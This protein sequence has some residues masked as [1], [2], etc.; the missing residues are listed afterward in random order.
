MTPASRRALSA[1]NQQIRRRLP[2]HARLLRAASA[3]IAGQP[4]ADDVPP[5]LTEALSAP[6]LEAC[7]ADPLALG[8]IHQYWHAAARA[9]ADGRPRGG[10]TVSAAEV[11]RRTQLF[12]EPYLVDWILERTLGAAWAEVCAHN[13]WD[14]PSLTEPT[15][16]GLRSI[17]DLR[18]LDPAVGSGH[19][20]VS[21][22]PRLLA[23]HA[24]E[25]RLRG[26]RWS[27]E[28]SVRWILAHSL[29]GVDI[30]PEAV[31][32]ARAAL[33]LCARPFDAEPAGVI[34]SSD[35]S[36]SLGR[37]A[38]VPAAG[39]HHLV[40]GNPPYLSTAKLTDARYIR[41]AYPLGRA[42]LFAAFLLRGLE[43]TCPGG[44][45]A[46]LTPR[47][48]M[49]TRQY[50]PLRQ[51]LLRAHRLRGLC[52]VGTG[53]FADLSG[54][55][56]QVCVSVFCRDEPPAPPCRVLDL[57]GARGSGGRRVDFDPAALAVVPGQPLVY[58][59]SAA[60][61]ARFAAAP[62]L[63]ERYPVRQGLC[64][65]DNG[66]FL[67]RP[68]EVARQRVPLA[69][70]PADLDSATAWLPFIKGGEGARWFEPLRWVVNWRRGG[71][72]IRLGADAGTLAARPQNID[73]YLVK[74]TAV[75]TLGG[76]FAGRQ[77]RYPSV[78]GDMARSVFGDPDEVVTFLN[79]SRTAEEARAL[80][81][82][83]HVTVSDLKR[84]AYQ[85]DPAAG[86]I[87]AIL[88]AAFDQH[89]RH[90]EPSVT[91]VAPGPSPWAAAQS[92]AQAATDRPEGAPL[93]P[94][95]PAL[96]PASDADQL[97]HAFGLVLRALSG[98][99]LV[100]AAGGDDLSHPALAPLR[101]LLPEAALRRHLRRGFFV[102]HRAR[103]ADR[104]IYWPLCAPDR[105][106][107]VWV[108]AASPSPGLARLDRHPGGA[109]L[110]ER[111]RGCLD[112]G[113]TGTEQPA[114][115]EPSADDGFWVNSAPLHPVLSPLWATPAKAWAALSAGKADWSAMARRHWPSRVA[116]R[117]ATDPSV[118]VAHGRLWADHPA[119]AWRWS[120]RLPVPDDPARIGYIRQNPDEAVAAVA[121]EVR[122]RQGR[123]AA[124]GPLPT[125]SVPAG[126]WE[127]A[128][129]ACWALE[130]S[131]AAQQRAPFSLLAPDRAA[132]SVYLAQQPG[133]AASVLEAALLTE[134]RP[135]TPLHT[136]V[137]DAPALAGRLAAIA[138]AVARKQ[139]APISLRLPEA[140]ATRAGAGRDG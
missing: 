87:L 121:A 33:R 101:A 70:T 102:A 114:P 95:T 4:Q 89:E 8:W 26:V 67:R 58:T 92:W 37:A 78:F 132:R 90:R 9:G 139:G 29:H 63:G 27:R 38:A 106:V 24:E 107:V 43:L 20:L 15:R 118:A 99:L 77:H 111:L 130:V 64:T 10:A 48:W 23:L 22:F 81:P 16:C 13:G 84:L 133:A 31:A 61:I 56:V 122:R 94:Y 62:K 6:G 51:A 125:M 45:S 140:D 53:A 14:A 36:G 85:A 112:R 49:F 120:L 32:V 57:T 19:F 98:A 5:W 138:A 35:P 110:A 69:A 55:V 123:G 25:A 66:R 131:V 3:H 60:R 83:L 136:V 65:G 18:L 108:L 41:E 88:S 72:E 50:T 52:D 91:F 93:P 39:R 96:R 103:Y 75:Q 124:R 76:R 116:R 28:A 113:P 40:V 100:S 2:D 34:T 17:R 73:G 135:R 59:W 126:L 117:C 119:A 21:A 68:W 115:Y 128:P 11:A 79:A 30:D 42:D 129:A 86:G 134:A 109:A 46:L 1:T 105:S 82:T 71:L 137:V 104:P 127:A 47:A 44:L 74:G 7:W 97:S 80:S 12:T 54:E